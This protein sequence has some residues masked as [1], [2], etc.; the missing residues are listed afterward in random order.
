[1]IIEICGHKGA[2]ETEILMRV[3]CDT[4]QPKQSKY[5]VEKSSEGSGNN[6]EKELSI[7]TKKLQTNQVLNRKKVS[8][9]LHCITKEKKQTTKKRNMRSVKVIKSSQNVP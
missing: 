4:G 1:M 8:G 9:R 2:I 7:K 5:K 6:S 3:V